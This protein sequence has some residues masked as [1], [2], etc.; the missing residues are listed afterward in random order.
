[1][2][3]LA[4][5]WSGIRG[6][7]QRRTIWLAEVRDSRL[8][9]L[10]NGR[11]RDEVADHLIAEAARD[12]RFVVGFDFAFSFPAWFL[13][14][15]GLPDAPALWDLAARAG[16]G[17]LRDCAPPFW[18]RPGRGKPPGVEQER[19][20]DR[21]LPRTAGIVPKP[22]FQIGGAGA[23]GTGSLRGMP[24]LARLRAAGCA[25]WPFDPPGWPR[26]V[27]IYPR[28]LTGPVIKSSAVARAAYLAVRPWLGQHELRARA[29]ASEDAFDAAI[30]AL[31]MAAHAADLADLPATAEP[32]IL[33]EGAIWYPGW[34]GAMAPDPHLAGTAN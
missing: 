2:R 29:A 8:V 20:T 16:E 10:E 7:G 32:Q 11:S 13:A 14:A 19:R 34:R 24:I 30:A 22:A 28:I 17:W 5:D 26:V 6:P 23:V 27:E 4:L 15:R 25:V 12:P 3:L 1:M 31:A 9:R 33:R 18:G 21:A